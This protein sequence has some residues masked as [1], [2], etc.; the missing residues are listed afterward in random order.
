MLRDR[1]VCG[2]ADKKVQNR[3]LRESKLTYTEARDLAHAALTAAKDSKKL[4]EHDNGGVVIG[5]H[6]ETVAH[7]D[8]NRSFRSRPGKGS[9]QRGPRLDNKGGGKHDASKCKFKE[10]VCRHCY[11]KGHLAAA[12]ELRAQEQIN[13]VAATPREEDEYTLY[14]VSSK[15]TK[16]FMVEVRLNGIDTAMEVDTGASVSILSFKPLRE[17]GTTLRRSSAKL[18][19]YR[20]VDPCSG[21]CRRQS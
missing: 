6:K 11:K 3:Y 1:L 21:N 8:K 19:L 15:A 13:L 10:Y 14:S 17:S 2:V 5:V 4:S 9:S 16:P 12:R 20:G 18:H 7:I